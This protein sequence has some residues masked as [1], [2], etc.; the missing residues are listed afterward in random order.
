MS[1]FEGSVT[2]AA[3]EN[4]CQ[5]TLVV[6]IVVRQR[7][8]GRLGPQ[9]KEGILRKIISI[10]RTVVGAGRGGGQQENV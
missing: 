2:E 7:G 10:E 8:P 3:Q 1:R 9:R 5:R 6:L 4:I